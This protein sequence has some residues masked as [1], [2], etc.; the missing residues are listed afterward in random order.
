M[1]HPLTEISSGGCLP[2]WHLTRTETYRTWS[3][4]GSAC[5]LTSTTLPPWAPTQ[6]G[7]LLAGR[8]PGAAAVPL[9]HVWQE[10]ARDIQQAERVGRELVLDRLVSTASPPPRVSTP[11]SSRAH[12][13]LASSQVV[14]TAHRC[15]D[16]RAS[17]TSMGTAAIRSLACPSAATRRPAARTRWPRLASS[18][19]VGRPMPELG[20]VASTARR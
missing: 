8:R 16:R 10:C 11:H 18:I 17:V 4:T 13:A 5:W 19:A 14:D 1:P 7:R 12:R 15:L 2:D 3:L 20:P 9:T 6:P